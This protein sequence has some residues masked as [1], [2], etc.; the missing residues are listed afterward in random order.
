[1][2]NGRTEYEI[3]YRIG[4]LGNEEIDP[5][6]FIAERLPENGKPSGAAQVLV[7]RNERLE[8]TEVEEVREGED[9]ERARRI[10]EAGSSGEELETTVTSRYEGYREDDFTYLQI[11]VGHV[12]VGVHRLSVRVK[13]VK[14]G[15][16]ATREETF[17]V[18][19]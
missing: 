17:R 14:T 10:K 7:T 3:S 2:S 5:Y 19:E 16:V 15:Q 1:M 9:D 8:V 4:R 13:D 12:P 11:D 6:Q 18:I